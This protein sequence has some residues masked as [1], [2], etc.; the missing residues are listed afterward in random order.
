MRKLTQATTLVRIAVYGSVRTPTVRPR[1]EIHGM[2]VVRGPT[3]LTVRDP[4]S[5]M[6]R[7]IVKAKTAE[8]KAK[9]AAA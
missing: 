7:S 2:L 4:P 3:L 8:R 5:R 6:G 1:P 9:T